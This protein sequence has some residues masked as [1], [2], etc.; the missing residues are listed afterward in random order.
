MRSRTL[1]LAAIPIAGA[2]LLVAPGLRANQKEPKRAP[3]YVGVQACGSCHKSKATGNQVGAWEKDPH[4][5]AY[6]TLESEAAF[7]IA[8]KKGLADPQQASECL[9]CH[10]TGA[11]VSKAYLAEGFD[12][13]RG[14][15]CE[16]CH[17]AGE[18][19]AK[20][21]HMI[22]RSKAA[23]AGLVAPTA[24]VC[25]RC[26]NADSPTFKGFDYAS[27]VKKIAHPLAPK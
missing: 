7:A 14:V 4:A 1:G 27:A 23:E 24:A 19:Y 11:D 21:Q 8:K 18:H 6:K 5:N 15:Q 2:L 20:I 9:R 22:S 13:T 17:G 26:H 10:T 12:V 25:R 3:N 16:S